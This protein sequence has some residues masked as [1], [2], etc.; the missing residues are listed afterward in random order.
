MLLRIF[1]ENTGGHST[2]AEIPPASLDGVFTDLPY[3]DMVQYGE[4]MHFNRKARE[5]NV[6]C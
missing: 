2:E 3:F 1:R 5:S 6:W 4:L